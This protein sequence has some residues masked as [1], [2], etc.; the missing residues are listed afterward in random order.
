MTLAKRLRSAFGA[1]K[2]AFYSAAEPSRLTKGN[3]QER[4]VGP[5]R[6]V[7]LDGPAIRAKIRSLKRNN[8]LLAGAIR[9]FVSQVLPSPILIEPDVRRG[10]ERKAGRWINQRFNDPVAYLWNEW[11]K[12]ACDF[13][14][15]VSHSTTFEEM[16]RTLV[17]SLA[18]DGEI[19]AI[20]R[21]RA[22]APG[23]P[24]L[25]IELKTSEMLGRSGLSGAATVGMMVAQTGVDA[26]DGIE[27]D[28]AGRSIAYWFRKG[29][30]GGYAFGGANVERIPAEDVLHVMV[31]DQPGQ[32]IGDLPMAC[33]LDPIFWTG[34]S[35]KNEQQAQAIM[36][37]VAGVVTGA[38]G[39]GAEAKTDGNGNPYELL[40]FEDMTILR[41]SAE[42]SFQAFD[43][44]RPTSSFIELAQSFTRWIAAG[45]GLSYSV[46]SADF[47][48]LNYSV[49][50]AEWLTNLPFLRNWRHGIV[51][52]QFVERIYT[53]W[54]VPACVA[55]GLVAIP[56]S[57]TTAELVRHVAKFPRSAYID[58]TKDAAA[59]LAR[60]RMGESPQRVFGERGL[61]FYEE[62]EAWQQARDF[63]ESLGVDTLAQFLPE[64]GTAPAPEA[65]PARDENSIPDEADTP[66]ESQPAKEKMRNVA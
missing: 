9:S 22:S 65:K 62:V 64:P 52:A 10:P 16:Q 46:L 43:M 14:G 20:R 12:G 7:I 34:E 66:D 47:R 15:N 44:K 19:F 33:V 29:N 28:D 24:A 2:R 53:R 36:G 45:F 3:R 58:P 18:T 56:G 60:M 55:E 59:D 39:F 13:A 11:G 40:E 41:Q 17:R 5:D 26:R 49:S 27:Y 57:Y 4:G 31:P 42:G 1:A 38:D 23:L 63:A 48:G 54:F 50:R 21:R 51:Y 25:Q 8:A 35:W 32:Q 61:D 6:A 30:G 37:K